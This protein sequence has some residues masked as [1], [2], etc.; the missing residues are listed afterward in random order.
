MNGTSVDAND[1]PVG[2]YA[3]RL[4]EV[5]ACVVARLSGLGG[6]GLD[7][8][9]GVRLGRGVDGRL[10]PFA[11]TSEE[12]ALALPAL[13][14]TAVDAALPESAVRFGDAWVA[15]DSAGR[16]VAC[17]LQG[18]EQG[19]SVPLERARHH[20]DGA[21]VGALCWGELA[22][23]AEAWW[24]T[25]RDVAA[26]D[27]RV[28]L[29]ALVDDVS[30]LAA[31]PGVARPHQPL[32]ELFDRPVERHADAAQAP[33]T[34]RALTLEALAASGVAAPFDLVRV[35]N[36]TPFLPDAPAASLLR[37][38]AAVAREGAWLVE[39][40]TVA[41]PGDAAL[42]ALALAEN[43]GGT[44]L[45]RELWLSPAATPT[46][47][48]RGGAELPAVLGAAG[49][50]LVRALAEADRAIR[51]TGALPDAPRMAA[52]LRAR[53]QRGLT[54]PGLALVGLAVRA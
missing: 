19:D 54:V 11:P 4:R 52:A 45:P 38:A 41:L 46:F 23:R 49:P 25:W 36:V 26:R 14:V 9:C 28:A 2:T 44:W 47:L 20:P 27:G 35:A 7:V 6:R 13:A 10:T 37:A 34:A 17:L 16:A 39:A 40:G 12:L 15:L 8:G 48:A 30:A 22:P 29:P 53:G 1:L 24:A 31:L 50:P 33:L 42:T 18:L 32:A 3:R 51:Q 21:R 5:D 43:S